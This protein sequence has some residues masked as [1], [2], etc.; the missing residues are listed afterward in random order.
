[1]AS[2]NK[3][4]LG[5]NQWIGSDKPKWAD[6]N[7]DNLLL[8]TELKKRAEIDSDGL[9]KQE[10][11]N[12][13]ALG[14]KDYNVLFD[15]GGAAKNALSLNGHGYVQLFDETGAA[16][17]ALKLGGKAFSELFDEQ[18]RALS[19]LDSAKLGGKNASEFV[20]ASTYELALIN[21]F[22][23]R[24]GGSTIHAI[25]MG[26]F[27][28]ICGAFRNSAPSDDAR[29]MF[30]VPE[31]LRPSYTLNYQDCIN[32]GGFTYLR[33]WSGEFMAAGAI[34]EIEMYVMYILD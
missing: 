29:V 16:N 4:S 17:N 14:G 15:S 20:T 28:V 7:A 25:K 21:G 32:K 3:T 5:F 9:V 23:T 33:E 1:M 6:F 18:K 27:V 24:D 22:K 34:V 19:A 13:K 26:N 2:T 10:A 11:K 31:G 8:D 30:M 12:S